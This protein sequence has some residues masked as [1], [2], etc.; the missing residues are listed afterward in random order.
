M[1]FIDSLHGLCKRMRLAV[2]DGAI[3]EPGNAAASL[4]KNLPFP[5]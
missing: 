4:K 3:A 1:A 2:H 5:L